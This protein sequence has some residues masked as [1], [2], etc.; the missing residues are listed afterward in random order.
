MSASTP[1]TLLASTAPARPSPVCTS[2]ATR[3]VPVSRQISATSLSTPAGCGITPF[4]WIGSKKNAATDSSSNALRRAS[5]FPKGT[6]RHPG[7]SG[8]KP[9]RNQSAPLI[10][11]AP[12]VS[13][14][15]ALDQYANPGRPVAARAIFIAA[16]IDSAPLL[17]KNTRS[18]GRSTN[19]FNDSA[20]ATARGG[21]S[22]CTRAGGAIRSACSSASRTTGWLRPSERL[23]KPP[24]A[25]R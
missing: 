1:S 14:W 9:R 20:S 6:S 22:N 11:S 2:S 21:V 18:S 12:S 25:S 8:S 7:I 10:E 17:T 15:N 3:S 19:C 23:A 16:S 13:P 5:R 4:P 24:I